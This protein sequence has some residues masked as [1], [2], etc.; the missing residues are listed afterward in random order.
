VASSRLSL[1][2]SLVAAGIAGALV[3]C[4]S[5]DKAGGY[6]A[7]KSNLTSSTDSGSGSASVSASSGST[8]TSATVTPPKSVLSNDVPA[9]AQRLTGASYPP[10]G[11]YG[12]SQDGALYIYDED[13][14]S[15]V[16][17]TNYTSALAGKPV[18]IMDLSN[19]GNMLNPQHKYSIFYVSQDH[20]T[21]LPSALPSGSGQ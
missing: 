15:V 21:T 6:P 8:G 2:A 12:P 19:I 14:K 17:I 5:N 7:P 4:S 20:V 9:G 16:K 10:A 11:F 13:N 18:N 3:G 1:G